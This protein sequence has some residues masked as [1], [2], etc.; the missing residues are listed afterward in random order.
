MDP[1][2]YFLTQKITRSIT[3]KAARD[4]TAEDGSGLVQQVTIYRWVFWIFALLGVALGLGCCILHHPVIGLVLFLFF[5]LPAAVGLCS[6]YNCLLTYDEAGFTWRNLLRSSRRYSYED[7]TGLYTSP[8]RVVVELESGKRLDLDESWRNRQSF[9]QAIRKYRSQKPPKLV[10]PV[11]GMTEDEIRTSYEN[12]ILSRA[13]LVQKGDLPRFPLF[14]ALHYGICTLASLFAAFAVFCSPGF[15]ES[16]PLP[17]FLVL[18]LPGILLMAA[19]LFLYFRY[20][21]YFTA[22]EKPAA[23]LLSPDSKPRHKCCTLALVS[24]LCLP[25]SVIFFLSQLPGK[26]GFWTLFLAAGAAGF[27]LFALL[28]WFRRFSWEYRNFRVGYVSFAVW[29]VLLCISVFFTLGG[30]FLF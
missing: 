4:G 25:G 28:A 27:L 18:A 13:M 23:E 15:W 22:R 21:Q 26:S 11:L 5:D 24:L 20:P 12:G 30:L 16:D 14:K 3:K 1:L 6:Q 9:A 17:G 19:A 10:P 8:L 7:V 29:Q 2:A